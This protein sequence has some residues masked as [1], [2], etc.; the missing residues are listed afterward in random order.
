MLAN[1]F[2][3][4]TRN[5]ST[6]N[7]LSS[8]NAVRFTTV[9]NREQPCESQHQRMPIKGQAT[10]ALLRQNQQASNELE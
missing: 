5:Q 10:S 7:K 1:L 3:A 2:T 4:T 6:K 9:K 8:T